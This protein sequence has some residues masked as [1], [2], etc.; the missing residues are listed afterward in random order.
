MK[1]K[2]K[3]IISVAGCAA[4]VAGTVIATFVAGGHGYKI[5][6]EEDLKSGKVMEYSGTSV[7]FPLAHL[8]NDKG[9]IISYDV[10]YT[11]V[12]QQNGKETTNEYATFELGTGQYKII[13]SDEGNKKNKK[14]L[15][16]EIKDTKSPVISFTNIPRGLF[17]QD[18]K[19]DDI[20]KLPLYTID[21]ASMLDGIDLEKKLY[22]KGDGDRDFKEV[23]FKE[24]NNSYT[25]SQFGTFQYEIKAT[26]RYGNSAL[27]STS[28][29]VKDRNWKPAKMPD[30]GILADYSSDG[31]LNY[32]EPG[33]AN[34]YYKIGNEYEDSWLEEYEGAK[35][36]LKADLSF[37]NAAGWGNNCVRLY[38]ARKL[39][40]EELKG[41][42]L[43]VRMRVEGKNIRDHFLFAGS[44]VEFRKEDQTM[45]A[46]STEKVG[47]ET[48]QWMT[49]YID[50]DL[51]EDIGVFPGATYNPSTTVYDGGAPAD[52][53][54]L[55]FS[56]VAGYTTD[57]TLYVD[58]ISIAQKLQST[59]V[60]IS[61][62]RATWDKVN[63]AVGYLVNLNGKEKT[64]TDT[65]IALDGKKGYIHVKPLGDGVLTLDAEESNAIYGIDP[66][67]SLAAFDDPLYCEMFSDKLN[68]S[69]EQEHI[70]YKPKEFSASYGKKSVNLE[71]GTGNW[72]VCTG[73]KMI[74]PKKIKKGDNTSI[75]L[76]MNI[77]NAS[78]SGMR[79]FDY[80]GE[81]LANIKLSPENTGRMQDYVI[82]I[83]SYDKVLKGLQ[84]V[85]GPSNGMKQVAK[86]VSLTFEN[87]ALKNSYYA[88]T[89]DGKSMT[90]VGNKTLTPGYSTDKLVQFMD[91]FDFGV[92][93]DNTPLSFEGTLLING[94]A[95]KANFIGYP[96]NKTI[97]LNTPHN[98]KVVTVMKGSKIY[99]GD[100]VAIIDQ[101]FNAYWNGKEWITVQEIPAPPADEYV[102][103]NGEKKLV[104]NKTK[105]NPGITKES[106][107]QFMEFCDFGV[108]EENTPL[109][110]SGD[111][112]MDG[113]KISSDQVAVVGYP[114]HT[115][116]CFNV[117]HHGKILTVMKDSVVYY[118]DKAA[119]VTETFNAYWD[120]KNW[121]NVEKV[122]D[123]PADEYVT[124]NDEQ[125]LVCN[126][127]KLT[128]GYTTENLVQFTDFYDFGAK[129]DNEPLGFSG[130]LMIDGK[131]LPAE[132]VAVVGYPQNTTICFNVPH[133]GKILTVMKDSVVYSGDKAVVIS[134]T[135]NAHWNG[136][137]WVT[138]EEIP[139]PPADEYV[140]VGGQEKLV[141]DKV[142]LTPGYTQKDLVQFTECYDFK[143]PADN[144]PLSFEGKILVNGN[145]IPSDG[146]HWIGYSNNRT[147]CLNIPHNG[148][149]LTIMKDSV[150]AYGDY[151]LIVTETFN[152]H[153]DGT[154]WV[155]DSGI[156]APQGDV[157]F[158]YTTG[159]A[160]MIQ[161]KTDLPAD[162]ACKN[163]LSTDNGSSILQE[164]S[165]Q[166][167]WASMVK[168]DDNCIYI[169]F[170]FDNAF[171]V[172]QSYTLKK[173][174]VFKF[175]DGS[176]YTL[177]N[178]LKLQ[179]TENGWEEN[180]GS[181]MTF[182]NIIE[183]NSKHFIVETD[184]PADTPLQ[185]FLVTDNGC[186]IIES[187]YKNVGYIAMTENNGKICLGFYFNNG[188]FKNKQYVL[189]SGSV[190][191]FTDGSSYTLS[192]EY[193]FKFNGSVFTMV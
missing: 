122:P 154:K 156:P 97:C 129:E 32:F 10:K 72:D 106:L 192:K 112:R 38:F 6:L 46:F 177:H 20:Q 170:V 109:M 93:E 172:G 69:T 25:V 68:F 24:I 134:E 162:T 191:Q 60:K 47:L 130:K 57:M 82:D 58:S 44:N 193:A 27:N 187:G 107:V 188:Y 146:Y 2:A 49:F 101:T 105:L 126:K 103:I 145:E 42:Y 96:K 90:C 23:S 9:E 85:F 61:G 181:E 54:Q 108:K 143:V 151:A 77:S 45:R 88:I 141:A 86:G 81:L 166:F 48:D 99:Y 144:T 184:L 11:V 185:D 174:S 26:D 152:A 14:E 98:G 41:K 115:T 161:V 17:L 75:V 66:H 104:L 64:V 55:C 29:L 175:S 40:R 165:Q 21:D 153:W 18:I 3:V 94:K 19:E 189:G 91:F 102:T 5:V 147:L 51:A 110:F 8:E 118:G 171:S 132:N 190:F 131:E 73:I 163:F 123:A 142:K 50:G 53:I 78:Y 113:K 70:G 127:T 149:V 178:T 22:F 80:D 33:D 114:D 56:R 179:F 12:D 34:Q 128:P 167:G 7:Q 150:I 139:N 133:K 148:K 95:E 125:K 1:P 124:V 158:V 43:A 52:Y 79:V 63:G 30:S 71:L 65:S 87:I 173:G 183:S 4:V 100:K 155:T 136:N 13:Y 39:S 76:R 120:G 92:P 140:T 16:F 157:S 135:F 89:V 186:S 35:G 59:D 138:D 119:V 28:W 116:I 159:H 168:G 74:F 117:P 37:N 160:T 83:G 182:E 164:G 36:V 62:N 121:V 84:F 169:G 180:N 111:L 31:Y 67:G 176:S 15:A 137:Q